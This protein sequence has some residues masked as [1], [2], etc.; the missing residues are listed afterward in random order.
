MKSVFLSSNGCPEN[1]I[2]VARVRTYL[3]QNGWHIADDPAMA[4]LI[5]FN[6][7]GLT[8]GL[9]NM[10]LDIIKELQGKAKYPSEVI[11]WGCLPKIDPEAL[12]QVYQ[13]PAFSERELHKL[14][15][16]IDAEKPIEGMVA[17][18]ISTCCHRPEHV[19][20]D[21]IKKRMVYLLGSYYLS[22]AGKLNLHRPNDNSIFYIKASTGCVSN[23]AYC[24]VRNSRGRIKSKRIDE[25]VDEFRDGL[26]RGFREFSL[27]GTD[28]GPQ[29]RD[30]GY[31]LADLLREMVKEKGEYKIGLR[32]VH[33]YFLKQMLSELQPVLSTGKVWY[34][35][36][37]AQSGS[38]RILKLMRRAYTAEDVRECVRTVKRAHPD[39]IVRTQLMV[40]FPTETRQDFADS[41]QLLND[42]KFD[43]TDVYKFSPRPRTIAAEMEGRVPDRVA[44]YRMYRMLMKLQVGLVTERVVGGQL[45]KVPLPRFGMRRRPSRVTSEVS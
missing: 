40:G 29:G 34:M 7:C 14:D 26:S 22:L 4:D 15:E 36:I 18:D 20:W 38:D 28:L 41:M 9:A 31:T 43:Y 13:G 42:T 30:L 21:S 3:Q 19:G 2:D 44:T 45:R 10:S 32:N 39:L 11:V 17:N 25:V 33:P 6:A 24:A 5:L 1:L 35:G 37:A 12:G 8:N 27:L 23:C 16:L